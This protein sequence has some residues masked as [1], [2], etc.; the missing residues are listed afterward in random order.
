MSEVY[1]SQQDAFTVAYPGQD[2]RG[3]QIFAANGQPLGVVKDMIFNTQ[4]EKVDFLELNDGSQVRAK[5]VEILE[6]RVRLRPVTP[7]I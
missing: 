5:D 2:V 7:I 1:Y 3:W 6:D 4:T